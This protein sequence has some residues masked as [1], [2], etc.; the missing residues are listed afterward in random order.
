MPK[1]TGGQALVQSLQREGVD[2]IFAL[3]GVQLDW[4]FDALYEARDSIRVIH[5]RHEQA[6]SYMADG[7]ARTT[8]RVGV[9]L[10]VPGP[11]LL[12]A[13]AGLSTAYSASSQ[14]LCIAGQIPSPIIGK[15]RGALHEIKDQL[16]M[17]SSVTKWSAR[18]M[19]PAEVPRVVREAFRQMSTGRP[20]PVEIE[21][22]PDVLM[23]QADVEIEEPGIEARL[24]GDPDALE[25]AARALGGS[26]RPLIF[27]GGGAI[28]GEVGEE[29]Q[30]L[31]EML[32]APVVLSPTA[33]GAISSRHRLTL[34]LVGGYELFPTA[35]VLLAVGTRFVLQGARAWNL[36]PGQT[37]IHL[38]IDPEEVG[39]TIEPT[40]GIV[41]DVKQ[42]ITELLRRIP[43]HNRVRSPRDDELSAAKT[44]V[45]RKLASLSPLGD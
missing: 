25:R 44:V 6:T 2:V 43:R 16:G 12:N 11:G 4:A 34:P 35:D 22:P 3:P 8:G 31:A 24:G 27:A 37:L 42:G 32:E 10:T 15:E 30:R 17:I 41:A 9:C 14:V 23:N 18:A 45:A 1:L 13:A 20:R 26:L 5:T 40:V 36:R 39:R 33:K 29:L 28:S 21:I 7:Y 19:T 38:D